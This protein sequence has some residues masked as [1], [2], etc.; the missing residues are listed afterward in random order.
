MYPIVRKY[1]ASYYVPHNLCLIV[2]GKLSTAALLN[3]IQT[4]VEPSIAA[5]NQMHG[6]RPAGWKRPFIE[7]PSV[8]PVVLTETRKDTIEFPEKD[9]TTGEVIVSFVG[10]SSND[11]LQTK[12][13]PFFSRYNIPYI[14]SPFLLSNVHRSTEI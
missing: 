4:Q 11:F 8:G 12:V 10:P 3:T 9:E 1:H 14:P 2:A 13:C 5:H 7:T 6:P